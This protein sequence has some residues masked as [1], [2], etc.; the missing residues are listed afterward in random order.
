MMLTNKIAI[1]TGGASGIG[2]SICEKLAAQGA[3]IELVDIN[4]SAADETLAALREKGA[5]IQKHIADVC[6]AACVQQIVNATIA[7]YGRID[8]LVN[9]AG[10]S[11]RL[12][13]K[14][15]NFIDSDPETW[16]WVMN[17][18]LFAPMLWMRTVL[19]HMVSRESGRIINIASI[20]GIRAL[21][22]H[23]DYSA[24][25]GGLIALTRTVAQE[26]GKKGININ[27]ISPGSIAT[28]DGSPE[29]FLPGVGLPEDI[30]GAVAFLAS[31]E[32]RF[33]TGQNLAVDGGRSITSKC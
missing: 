22:G 1:V 4:E 10:G 26:V 18:N 16:R 13:G 7:E 11:A 21:A 27:C 29:T 19:P 3:I 24:S 32:A 9:N 6:D 14:K 17:L 23:A 15:S 31:D 33:I 25:K 30:A 8:I 28:R 2:R 20:A 5:Q 12:I